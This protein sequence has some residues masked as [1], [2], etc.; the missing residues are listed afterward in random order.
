[1]YGIKIVWTMVAII[2]SATAMITPTNAQTSQSWRSFRTM[3][4]PIGETLGQTA[5]LGNSDSLGMANDGKSGPM[6]PTTPSAEFLRAMGGN[7]FHPGNQW[8]DDYNNYF[9]PTTAGYDFVPGGPLN[10]G[11]HGQR[12]RRVFADSIAVSIPAGHQI[13]RIRVTMD[14]RALMG[15]ASLPDGD[16][17]LIAAGSSQADFTAH[18][19]SVPHVGYDET[20][21]ATGGNPLGRHPKTIELSYEAA[22]GT[23]LPQDHKLPPPLD[24]HNYAKGLRLLWTNSAAGKE[25]FDLLNRINTAANPKIHVAIKQMH[26]VD[27]VNVEWCSKPSKPDLGMTWNRRNTDHSTSGLITV[28]CAGGTFDCN[29]Y[30]GDT[31][32]TTELPLLCF[33][34]MEAPR[35]Q[36][37]I[38]PNRNNRWS[39]G[40]VHT[41]APVAASQFSTV[42]DANAACEAEFGPGWRVAE[43]HDGWGWNFTAYGNVGDI[44][45]RFWLDIND[46]VGGTCWAR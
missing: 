24:Q 7:V 14:I 8:A 2:G 35:P 29:P 33:N 1:M 18:V 5:M 31:T 21:I 17:I 39:G 36:S 27:Y 11:L 32:C 22:G 6:V 45:S 37:F 30:Q 42:R 26:A 38:E 3:T 41:T 19:F 20:L 10:E 13:N 15:N 44:T 12:I 16:R 9:D 28:G 40:L 25:S 46:Q 23:Y 34:N 4:C 43:F